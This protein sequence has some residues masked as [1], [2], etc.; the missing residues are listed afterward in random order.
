MHTGCDDGDV[1]LVGG[2]TPEEGRVEIC[3]NNDWGTVCDDSW[4]S[5]DAGVVCRQL[6]LPDTGATAYSAAFFGQ[7]TGPILLDEVNCFG[8]ESRLAFC[9][10]NPIGNHNCGHSEDAGVRCTSSGFRYATER[11][12]NKDY[13]YLKGDQSGIFK[14]KKFFFGS[15]YQTLLIVCT[16]LINLAMRFQITNLATYINFIRLTPKGG[17]ME[18][19]GPGGTCPPLPP[20][21]PPHTHTHTSR[22]NC[23]DHNFVVNVKVGMPKC[24][25][26]FFFCTLQVHTFYHV[27][28][29]PPPP[30][31]KNIQDPP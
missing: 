23:F 2:A 18:G 3:Y 26:K 24:R 14:R 12:F 22:N 20:P 31:K 11:C 30:P 13:N 9:P 19:G 4:D 17:S 29:L 21:P 8:T 1:R 28:T 7:G 10:A 15:V 27:H 6:G 25:M 5:S 16:N